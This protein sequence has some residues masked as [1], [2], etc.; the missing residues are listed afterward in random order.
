MP[1]AILYHRDNWLS[2]PP[3]SK[4][5]L[6]IR[7]SEVRIAA[8]PVRRLHTREPH[9]HDAI[10]VKSLM[11]CWCSP[12]QPL[13]CAQTAAK[14]DTE[15][16]RGCITH[17]FQSLHAHG[18]NPRSTAT[19]V[20]C[21]PL[22]SPFPQPIHTL[23]HGS[24]RMIHGGSRL[25]RG[26]PLAASTADRCSSQGTRAARGACALALDCVGDPWYNCG[27]DGSANF[28]ACGTVWC[29]FFCT[30]HPPFA[31]RSIYSQPRAEIRPFYLLAH[32]S[33]AVP[34]PL[35]ERRNGVAAR[36]QT[37]PRQG[38]HAHASRAR[39]GDAR[40]AG[41]SR[42]VRPRGGYAAHA[43]LLHGWARLARQTAAPG[44]AR[45]LIGFRS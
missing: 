14:V 21:S 34:S 23:L 2:T 33:G 43:L 44:A 11:L 16:L 3:P 40:N 22:C 30:P 8:P 18:C 39:R 25:P 41:V 1:S 24:T 32:L 36:R 17:H 42:L 5:P 38:M 28:F 15:R 26:H 20:R 45:P 12:Y 29:H 6:I 10:V 35:G 9:T 19:D 4:C 7:F 31:N 13:R 37:R 27:E